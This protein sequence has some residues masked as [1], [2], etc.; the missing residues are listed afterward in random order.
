MSCRQRPPSADR[1]SC[2]PAPSMSPKYFLQPRLI[3]INC[4]HFSGFRLFWS[5]LITFQYCLHGNVRT[6]CIVTKWRP[7]DSE[8]VLFFVLLILSCSKSGFLWFFLLLNTEILLVHQVQTQVLIQDQHRCYT[9]TQDWR[10]H[11]RSWC[12][13][14]HH[15]DW[16]A[17]RRASESSAA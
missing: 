16:S 1:L 9:A 2:C 7:T 4:F 15:R 6:S 3:W 13:P 10:V 12:F 14:F 8:R 17:V 5:F 11:R